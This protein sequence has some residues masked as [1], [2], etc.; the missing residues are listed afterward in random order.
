MHYIIL[1][2]RQI[3][4]HDNKPCSVNVNVNEVL[5]DELHHYDYTSETTSFI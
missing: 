1:V 3:L 5:N 2:Y 4:L